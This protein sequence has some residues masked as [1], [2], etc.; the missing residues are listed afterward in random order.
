M[1]LVTNSFMMQPTHIT[2]HTV[3]T[4]ASFHRTLICRLKLNCFA[5]LSLLKSKLF[6]FQSFSSQLT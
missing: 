4:G 2:Y 1:I 3:L 6:L 5:R